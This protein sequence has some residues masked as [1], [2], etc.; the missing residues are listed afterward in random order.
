M[1]QHELNACAA[2]GFGNEAAAASFDY[3]PG[4]GDDEESWARGLT[5]GLLWAHRT[6]LLAAGR[7][8]VAVAAA[9]LI[10]AGAARLWLLVKSRVGCGSGVVTPLRVRP[11]S[12]LPRCQ[13]DWACPCNKLHDS[14]AARV[15]SSLQHS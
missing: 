11:R 1:N 2:G 12:K 7:D 4:A 3:V 15:S 10:A 13:T 14:S 6:A 5:P 9:E 8:G